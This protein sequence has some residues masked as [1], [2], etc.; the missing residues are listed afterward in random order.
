MLTFVNLVLGLISRVAQQLQIFSI[1]FAVTVSVGLFGLMLTLPM[2]Q[3]PMM[4]II[5]R[6]LSLFQR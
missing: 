2:L 4:L 3:M 5:E 6:L 1:G